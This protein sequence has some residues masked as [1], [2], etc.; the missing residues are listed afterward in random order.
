MKPQPIDKI[1]AH[2]DNLK[3][4]RRAALIYRLMYPDAEIPKPSDPRGLHVVLD[5]LKRPPIHVID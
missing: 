2:P 1:W 4:Y 5:I 3:Q